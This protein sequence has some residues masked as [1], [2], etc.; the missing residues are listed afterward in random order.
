MNLI[1]TEPLRTA[2]GRF[3]SESQKQFDEAKKWKAMYLY[4]LSLQSGQA[5]R[6]RQLTEEN[7]QLKQTR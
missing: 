7:N 1:K 5:L 3:A 6:I 2:N 4:M